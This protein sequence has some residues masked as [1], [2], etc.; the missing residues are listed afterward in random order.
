MKWS[1]FKRDLKEWIIRFFSNIKPKNVEKKFILINTMDALGD[2]LV[3]TKAVEK[4]AEHYGKENTYILCKY[5][6]ASIYERLGYNV[7]ID[8]Y[9]GFFKRIKTYRKINSLPLKKVIY[10][11]H[12]GEMVSEKLINC[13][14]KEVFKGVEEDKYILD[15]HREFLKEILKKDFSIAELKPNLKE[16]Y[17]DGTIKN[18]I[19]IGIGAA[20]KNKT[21][22]MEKMLKIVELVANL[23]P[24]KRV[25]L[26]GSGKKQNEYSE[27]IIDILGKDNIENCVDK[28]SLEEVL[29]YVANSDLFIGYDSG[30]TNAAFAFG[31]NYICLHWNTNKIWKHNFEKCVTL[32]GDG[33]IEESKEYGTKYLN[34]IKLE[35][36]K[37]AIEKLEI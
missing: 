28:F 11:I 36:V 19:T 25:L 5:K 16:F 37:K 20:S 29:K 3:K 6:W 33:N 17:K 35:D 32:V 27:K 26:L 23:Y 13:K 34:T 12:D 1:H 10:F 7:I 30:L 4:I 9:K 21:L 2:N 22:P 24:K 18:V 15:Y 31:T 8:Y 14:E